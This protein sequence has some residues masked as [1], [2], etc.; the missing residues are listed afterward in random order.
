MG[1]NLADGIDNLAKLGTSLRTSVASLQA[2]EQAA[3]LQGVAW[4]Q[5]EKGLITLTDV[6]GEISSGAAYATITDAWDRLNLSIE[7]VIRLDAADQIRV[8]T[9]AIKEHIPVAEQ[10]S[11]V[12]ELFGKR[13]GIGILRLGDSIEESKKDIQEF[14]AALSD[15]A[16]NDTEQMNDALGLLWNT[17]K[18]LSRAI[19]AENAPA[20]RSWVAAVREG[21]KVGGELRETV[22]RIAT[23]FRVV[24]RFIVEF[25]SFLGGYVTQ[26]TAAILI[27]GTFVIMLGR[28]AFALI[29]I[30]DT[31]GDVR[32][33]LGQTSLRI[34]DMIFTVDGFGG[35]LNLIGKGFQ[36]L[37]IGASVIA[38]LVAAYRVWNAEVRDSTDITKE[39]KG[40]VEDLARQYDALKD[41]IDGV[42]DVTGRSI[43]AM[44]ATQTELR[45]QADA[46]LAGVR[47]S[48]EYR[49]RAERILGLIERRA[50]MN[51]GAGRDAIDKKIASLNK[52]QHEMMRDA[53]DLMDQ[54][55][56]WQ[57]KIDELEA[58]AGAKKEAEGRGA[59]TKESERI[60]DRIS[61]ER[62]KTELS[63]LDEVQRQYAEINRWQMEMNRAVDELG[64]GYDHLREQIASVAEAQRALVE[65]TQTWGDT[66]KDAFSGA[67]GVF[68]NWLSNMMDGIGDMEDMVDG[69]FK[70]I[71]Q[72]YLKLALFNP[73]ASKFGLPGFA[74]GGTVNRDGNYMVGEQG[75]EIVSLPAGARVYNNRDTRRMMRKGGKVALDVHVHAGGNWDALRNN[76]AAQVA[77][78]ATPI[79]DMAYGRMATDAQRS[80]AF[81]SAIRAGS[82]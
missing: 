5:L 74:Q 24:I 40:L 9:Q 12:N 55:D 4:K 16:A 52:E 49:E 66:L 53:F 63:K 71:A 77:R 38:M 7:D 19:V 72:H 25:A 36:I 41:S 21:L 22:D 33:A 14:G 10:A 37:V 48:D 62:W 32:L 60:Q 17:L 51:E 82:R 39:H 61:A 11:V 29:N 73:V 75:A 78:A 59:V 1:K 44:R 3:I 34:Q 46:M 28:I 69:L 27:G 13:V 79:A 15:T 6:L 50:H 81:Q 35:S 8:I 58:Q 65:P 47:G 56:E 80:S 42:S 68:D 2:L 30:V 64:P 67:E 70:M 23:G 26:T 31:L 43:D 20:I 54:A 76:I 45:A 57:R 18:N